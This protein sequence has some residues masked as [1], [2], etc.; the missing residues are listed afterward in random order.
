MSSFRANVKHL[1]CGSR[2]LSLVLAG[3]V[4]VVAILA[5]LL[6]HYLVGFAPS[7]MRRIESDLGSMVGQPLDAVLLKHNLPN[8]HSV[9]GGRYTYPLKSDTRE[10]G[11][12][13]SFYTLSLKVDENGIIT[14]AAI[15]FVD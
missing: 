2:K 7:E 4:F 15:E 14:S 5:A 9:E 13:P 3:G 8:Q 6:W 1:F 11:Y 12:G 10:V